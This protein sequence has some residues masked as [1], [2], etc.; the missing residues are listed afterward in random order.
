MK[1]IL[2][3]TFINDFSIIKIIEDTDNSGNSTFFETTGPGIE[4]IVRQ[5]KPSLGSLT[6]EKLFRRRASK[7]EAG[8]CEHFRGGYPF[9][10]IVAN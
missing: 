1:A 9:W 8:D 2:Y 10:E 6:I 4:A 7:V 5:R 3:F